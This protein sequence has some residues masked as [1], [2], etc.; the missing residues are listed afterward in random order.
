MEKVWQSKTCLTLKPNVQFQKKTQTNLEKRKWLK[1]L[2]RE[3]QEAIYTIIFLGIIFSLL[4]MSMSIFSQKLIDDILPKKKISLLILSISFLGFVLFARVS[5]QALRELYIIKQSKTFNV[6]INKKFYSSL[7]HLPKIFFDSRKIGDFVARLNDIQRIQTVIKQL[8][9]NTTVDILGVI[10]SIS[11][12][13]FYSWKLA[14]VCI[15]I[16]PLIFYIIFSFNKK[17][18]ESQRNVMQFYSVNEA[19]YIDSIRGIEVIKGFSK[20]DLFINKNETIF[21]S[22]QS[23]IFEQG[24]LSLKITLYSGLAV[25]VFLLLILGFSSY[26][27]LNNDIKTGELMAIIGISSSLLLSITNLALVTI[28]LQEAKVAFDRMFEYSSLEKEK[29]EGI[30]ITEIKSINIQNIDFRFNGRKKILNTASFSLHQGTVT[31]LLGESGSGKT[32]L[33]EILQKNYLPENGEIIINNDIA[34]KDIS[35]K[36]W[37]NLIGIVPQNIQLFNGTILENIILSERADENQLQKLFLLGFDKF[38]NSLPQGF[39][40]LAGEEGINLSGGQK[41]LIGWMRA[42]YHNPQFLIL[43]EPTSSLDQENRKFIY[44]LIQKMKNEKLIFIISHHLEDIKTISDEILLLED[45]Q[46]HP[47]SELIYDK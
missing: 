43:D 18:I 33:T 29:M 19:S 25:V 20:Q 11:F 23:K 44:D 21:S 34:L 2:I 6:R 9:T 22:F 8:I 26:S 27:V 16:S 12:L 7:L 31:C 30:G 36:D 42:L 46:I 37:R 5:I 32:T 45:T 4:G 40:T 35:L 14:L 15:I 10:I 28:P 38:V 1:N 41:Q 3:D 13:L 24:K 39:L 47:I 17:I